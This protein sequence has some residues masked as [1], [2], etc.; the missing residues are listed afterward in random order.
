MLRCPWCRPCTRARSSRTSRA[1]TWKVVRADGLIAPRWTARSTSRTVRA[2]TGIRP[3][4]STSRGRRRPRGAVRVAPDRRWPRLANDSPVPCP[5]RDRGGRA[6][7]LPAG[8]VNR[9]CDVADGRRSAH[10]QATRDATRATCCHRDCIRSP[11]SGVDAVSSSAGFRSP[12]AERMRWR[13]TIGPAGTPRAMVAPGRSAAGPRPSGGAPRWSGRPASAVHR[14]AIRSTRKT[15][16]TRSTWPRYGSMD[17]PVGT[18]HATGGGGLTMQ[19]A[20]QRHPIRRTTRRTAVGGSHEWVWC[21][22]VVVS[23]V[24]CSVPEFL[25]GS[26]CSNARDLG[27]ADVFF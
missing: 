3:S 2:R 13:P 9:R 4:S 5:A 23:A 15:G 16:W 26:G 18:R 24:G 11:A 20:R 10:R 27:R 1:T 7:T 14:V 17:D 22:A 8:T 25:G 12:T 6:A 21:R 19:S